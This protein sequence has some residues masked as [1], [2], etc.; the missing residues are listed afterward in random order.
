M[1][2]A[3]PAD[4]ARH[5]VSKDAAG[6]R[7]APPGIVLRAPEPHV[8]TTV[9][10]GSEGS[11]IPALD[12]VRGL[13]IVLVIVHHGIQAWGPAQSVLEKLWGFFAG[14]AWVG[15][16]LFF[17]LSGFLITGIL[18]DTK[19]KSRYFGSFYP[20][21]ML[22]TF[23]LY[24]ATILVCL[25]LLPLLPIPGVEGMR[26]LSERQGW[27]W[28]HASNFYT[29]E[30]NITRMDGPA[31][32]WMQTFWSLAVEEHFYLVWPLVIYWC[33]PKGV[34]K[35]CVGILAAG[36]LLRV[37]FLA[38]GRDFQYI[39][40]HT[41]TR[42]DGLILG[43]FV[44]VWMRR[45]GGPEGAA[46]A[47]RRILVGTLAALGGIVLLRPFSGRAYAWCA[48]TVV[49]TAVSLLFACLLVL[50]LRSSKT[51]LLRQLFS[52]R[53]LQACGRHSFAMYILNIPLFHLL[54]YAFD[55]GHS[56]LWGS[57]IPAIVAY[58]AAGTLLSL[59]GAL[60]T[61][62]LLEKHCLKLK[63]YFSAGDRIDPAAPPLA[64]KAA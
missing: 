56:V 3:G 44:A 46:K 50:V 61:W 11:H 52:G 32:G 10:R 48:G 37:L 28:L 9:G 23:P 14:H 4:G 49:F 12:G 30:H 13:A 63:K 31:V 20:R 25:V 42:L 15:V 38:Q 60:V 2:G 55:P 62:H 45:E 33:S 22:R 53:F 19:G 24:Y 21:R 5:V 6:F 29:L 41:F 18:L 17:V 43:S 8:P 1:F 16:D 59:G 57:R 39:Y 36:L 26:Q 64:R 54:D 27:F 58:T 47:A 7:P 35:T 51:S 40:R 34:L